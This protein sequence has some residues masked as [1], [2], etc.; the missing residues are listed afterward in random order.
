MVRQ[1]LKWWMAGVEEC[2]HRHWCH[3]LPERAATLLWDIHDDPS[4]SDELSLEGR[5]KENCQQGH[6]SGGTSGHA[7][8]TA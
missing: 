8:Y 5:L 7:S 3:T 1:M 4:T 2:V 6:R